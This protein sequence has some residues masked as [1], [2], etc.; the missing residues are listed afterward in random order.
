MFCASSWVRGR[1]SPRWPSPSAFPPP[2]RS[3]VRIAWA[4]PFHRKITFVPVPFRD[5]KRFGEIHVSDFVLPIAQLRFL[6]V[7]DV[8]RVFEHFFDALIGVRLF[9]GRQRIPEIRQR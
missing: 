5:S 3:R 1:G 2:C 8:V 4:V 9:V 7:R 6:Y